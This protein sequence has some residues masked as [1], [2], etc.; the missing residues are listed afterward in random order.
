VEKFL[1]IIAK[2]RMKMANKLTRDIIEK[3]IKKWKLQTGICAN[4][5]PY[6]LAGQLDQAL[7]DKERADDRLSKLYFDV[8][9]EIK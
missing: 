1:K 2:A 7:A 9:A 4:S 5:Y 6:S 3:A 8:L